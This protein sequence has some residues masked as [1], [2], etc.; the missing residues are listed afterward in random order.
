MLAATLVQMEV[1]T[2]TLASLTMVMAMPSTHWMLRGQ[3]KKRTE[4][5]QY[6]TLITMMYRVARWCHLKYRSKGL[7][8]EC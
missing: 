6:W 4:K 7:G 5:V 8:S 2:R 1:K 3:M